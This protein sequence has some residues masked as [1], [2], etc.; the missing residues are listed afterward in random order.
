M[1]QAA[2]HEGERDRQ[3]L[4]ITSADFGRRVAFGNEIHDVETAAGLSR[5]RF[6]NVELDLHGEDGNVFPE[7]ELP[8]PSLTVPEGTVV[9]ILEETPEGQLA[10]I[11]TYILD[12]ETQLVSLNQ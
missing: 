7:S 10:G 6:L 4:Q 3:Q 11:R 9:G 5:I 2:S 1:A 12:H 8:T